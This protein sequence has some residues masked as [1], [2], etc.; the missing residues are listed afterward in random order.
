[1]EM[2]VRVQIKPALIINLTLIFALTMTAGVHIDQTQ[3]ET[4]KESVVSITTIFPCC[5]P[6]PKEMKLS[7][8]RHYP[9]A[10]CKIS[11]DNR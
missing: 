9:F 11:K 10:L 1:M 5:D 4:I 2:Y 6:S 3:S 8:S 7:S